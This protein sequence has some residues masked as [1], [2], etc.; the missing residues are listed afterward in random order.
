VG[1]FDPAKHCGGKK[2]QGRGNCTRPKGWGTKHPGRGKC[3]LHGGST[4][5]HQAAAEREAVVTYGLPVEIDP[6]QALLEEVYRTAG[7]V[8]W[9]GHVIRGLEQD[10]VTRGLTKTVQLPDGTQRI[11]AGAGISVWVKLYQA[12]RAHLAKVAKAAVDAGIEERLVHIA[13]EQAKQL[14]GVIRA[15]VAALGH[16]PEDEEVRKVVRLHL[17]QG[18][19]AA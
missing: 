14:A 13:E 5:S 3:K 17:V 8:A 16:D 7:H 19:K 1:K 2:K 4:K 9:L 10:N 18:G 11:E 12:E 15:I 6:L